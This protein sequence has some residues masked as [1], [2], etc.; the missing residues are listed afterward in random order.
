M[1][2][3]LLIIL[4]LVLT[5]FSC[6]EKPASARQNKITKLS[7][8]TGG[9]FGECPFLAIE[10]DSTL[11]YKFYGGKYADLQG[12]YK[13]KISQ[14]FWDSINMRFGLLQNRSLDTN[15]TS[16]DDLS[17][18]NIIHFG[19]YVKA[20]QRQEMELPK[21]V[22]DNFYWLMD[23]Y[24]KVNLEKVADTFTFETVIQKGLPP[25][26]PPAMSED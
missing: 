13:G 9:C 16:A 24:K 3:R 1:E 7:F 6:Q 21:D 18:Q 23:S 19:Q 11:E 4:L 12:Y 26:P 10:I 8:A 22:R 17:F 2:R 15:I 14:T 5:L 20:I 25:V